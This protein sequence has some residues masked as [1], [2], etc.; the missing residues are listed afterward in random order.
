MS[1]ISK[2]LDAE[3]SQNLFDLVN[4]RILENTVM[5]KLD[6]LEGKI[7]EWKHKNNLKDG[8][9]WKEVYRKLWGKKYK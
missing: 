4:K 6:F 2:I 9:Y 1:P 5:S 7:D 8:R 3:D